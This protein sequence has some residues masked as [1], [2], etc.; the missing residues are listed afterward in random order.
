MLCEVPAWSAAG[1]GF[2][3]VLVELHDGERLCVGGRVQSGQRAES[4]G[5]ATHGGGEQEKTQVRG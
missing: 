1:D 4:Q 3:L 5:A 2:L